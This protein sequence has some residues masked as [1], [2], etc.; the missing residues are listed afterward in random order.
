MN[1]LYAGWSVYF[2]QCGNGHFKYHIICIRIWLGM[3]PSSG[4]WSF[5][6]YPSNLCSSWVGFSTIFWEE[7]QKL[8]GLK[9]KKQSRFE[10][11]IEVW[12]LIWHNSFC[13]CIQNLHCSRWSWKTFLEDNSDHVGETAVRGNQR[14][15]YRLVFHSSRPRPWGTAPW[16]GNVGSESCWKVEE[17]TTTKGCLEFGSSRL[18]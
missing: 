10:E 15:P 3:F 14:F 11:Q 9:R 12:I 6:G 7:C 8:K 2:K 16:S 5:I 18:G 13:Q 1:S 17:E 4:K